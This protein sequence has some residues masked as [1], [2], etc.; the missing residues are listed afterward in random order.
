MLT[1]MSASSMTVT[2]YLKHLI[3]KE[4]LFWLAVLE[5]P[6][7][8][9]LDI[10][11]ALEPVMRDQVKQEHWSTDTFLMVRTLKQSKEGL[12]VLLPSLWVYFQ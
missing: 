7:H 5:V 11:T 2:E 1:A 3:D 10:L 4:E 12:K 6:A 9:W 8:L